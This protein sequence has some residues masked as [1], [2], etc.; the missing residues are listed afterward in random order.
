MLRRYFISPDLDDLE[1]FELELEQRGIRTE[2][3][4]VLS[5]DDTSVENHQNL[6]EVAALMKRDLVQSTAYGAA[7][8][9]VLAAVLLMVTHF[10]GWAQT[11]AGWLPFVF[12]AIIVLGFFTWEGGLWGI[13][14]PNTQFERFAAELNAGRHVFFVDVTP[15]QE[16]ILTQVQPAHPTIE[17]AGEGTARPLWLVTWQFRLKRFFGETMP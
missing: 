12:L 10:A 17:G 3:I 1:R 11:G 8:G 4:H 15:A 9:A 7:A 13:Q 16:D 5:L 14:K 2:Q 6:H